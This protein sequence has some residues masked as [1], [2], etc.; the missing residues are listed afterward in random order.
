MG[1]RRWTIRGVGEEV[2]QT[3]NR[4]CRVSGMSAGAVISQS[5]EH[6]VMAH[7]EALRE[8]RPDDDD[9][10]QCLLQALQEKL[11]EQQRLIAELVNWA[12]PMRVDR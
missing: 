5:V 2:R 11:I 1:S 7:P 8:S 9:N 3:I 4:V 12:G 10:L 6:F